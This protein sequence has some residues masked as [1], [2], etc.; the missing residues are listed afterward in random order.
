MLRWLIFAGHALELVDHRDDQAAPVGLEQ[1]LEVFLALGHGDLA[2]ADRLQVAE[3]LGFQ[4]VAVHDHEDGRVLEGRVFD[5][6]LGDRDH[7]VGLARSLGVPDQ[8]PPLAGVLGPLDGP[9]DGSH[10]VRPQD[11]LGKL[12]VLAGEEDE[13][14]D[15][16]E[17][18]PG[19]DERLDQR[20]EVAP[21]ACSSRQLNRPL[22]E[23]FQVA[24]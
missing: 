7:R 13:V 3:E 11:G 21:L 17:H 15:D 4:L 6:P 9:L 12:L 24:P 18:S 14:G 16:P 10:L 23:R 8:A 20:L 19:G 2:E 1:F 5:Q 22:R